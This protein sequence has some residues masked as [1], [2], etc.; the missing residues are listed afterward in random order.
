MFLLQVI[1]NILLV[2]S[3]MVRDLSEICNDVNKAS[4]QEELGLLK[5]EAIGLGHFELIN[6]V[7]FIENLRKLQIL[8][9]KGYENQFIDLCKLIQYYESKG[10]DPNIVLGDKM[11]YTF[12]TLGLFLERPSFKEILKLFENSYGTRGFLLQKGC[13]TGDSFRYLFNKESTDFNFGEISAR[14]ESLISSDA[15]TFFEIYS[16]YFLNKLYEHPTFPK[17]ILPSIKK[18]FLDS[19]SNGNLEELTRYGFL[20][21]DNA[22]D[23]IKFENVDAKVNIIEMY[24]KMYID[25][26]NKESIVRKHQDFLD[27]LILSFGK[28]AL[29]SNEDLLATKLL[30]VTQTSNSDLIFSEI[31]ELAINSNCWS[32]MFKCCIFSILE[33]L[34]NEQ[35][36]AKLI[37]HIGKNLLG[38]IYMD[39]NISNKDLYFFNPKY[40][41]NGLET[42]AN[43]M[44]EINEVIKKYVSIINTKIL[45]ELSDTYRSFLI[46]Y[47]T[48]DEKPIPDRMNIHNPNTDEGKLYRALFGDGD[49][50]KMIILE[51]LGT[52]YTYNYWDLSEDN[53]RYINVRLLE[54][55]GIIQ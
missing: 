32:L 31:K 17:N 16:F 8:K 11:A 30:E 9:S 39:L 40:A 23:N 12:K 36:E 25:L 41:F 38:K 43:N 53:K 37:K 29:D 33:N 1:K 49:F 22:F 20:D 6:Y 26:L 13:S 34:K 45:R 7:Y 44:N 35:V 27:S 14:F 51:H 28:D 52:K 5:E 3:G 42:T 46:S 50:K 4:T 18:N 15:N 21:V 47:I 48:H 55:R 24:K 54:E 2:P 10:F 19:I